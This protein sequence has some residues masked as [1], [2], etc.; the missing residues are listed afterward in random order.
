MLGEIVMSQEWYGK[1]NVGLGRCQISVVKRFVDNAQGSAT[2]WLFEIGGHT[3]DG[4]HF[5]VCVTAA[6][7]LFCCFKGGQSMLGEI[8]EKS[9]GL[10]LG[11]GKKVRFSDRLLSSA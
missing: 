3:S 8:A 10:M 2:T 7:K 4:I 9:Q 5:E 11:G 1:G 6:A